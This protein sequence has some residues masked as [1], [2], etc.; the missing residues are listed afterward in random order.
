[1]NRTKKRAVSQRG[2]AEL[3]LEGTYLGGIL[4]K[5]NDTKCVRCGTYRGNTTVTNQALIELGTLKCVAR[6]LKLNSNFA[7]H[8]IIH[9]RFP[10]NLVISTYAISFH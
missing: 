10:T 8:N 5:D 3:K 2:A 7:C 4:D 6:R 9:L 1:M